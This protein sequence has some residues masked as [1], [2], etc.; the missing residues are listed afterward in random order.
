MSFLIK[1]QPGGLYFTSILPV[2]HHVQSRFNCVLQFFFLDYYLYLRL[3]F[4]FQK[5]LAMVLT[6]LYFEFYTKY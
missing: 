2:F 6:V 4:T 5:V 1:C 3:Y